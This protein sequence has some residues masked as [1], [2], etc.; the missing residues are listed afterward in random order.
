MGNANSVD[1]ELK[2]LAKETKD[3]L[4]KE[5]IT[6]YK[7]FWYKL[8]PSGLMTRDGLGKFV[9]HAFPNWDGKSNVDHLFRALDRD[10][11]GTVTFKEFILFQSVASPTNGKVDPLSL[12]DVVFNMYDID[13]NNEITVEELRES[14]TNIFKTYG[15]DVEKVEIK[16]MIETR[17]NKFL[18][19][20]DKN[21]DQKLT[22]KEIID[23]VSK[24]KSL[25]ALI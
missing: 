23:A 13:N 19:V 1:N 16:S 21:G 15:H 24:D 2:E 3:K 18:D 12:I 6:K 20:A 14:L 10:N 11:S 22:K 5:D 9:A 17:V 8:Y 25:L 4:T 7:T